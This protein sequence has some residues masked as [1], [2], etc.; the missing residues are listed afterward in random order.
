MLEDLS[1]LAV[2]FRLQSQGQRNLATLDHTIGPCPHV[3]CS[4]PPSPS[5]D[6]PLQ[7]SMVRSRCIDQYHMWPSTLSH[8]P[9]ALFE[10]P[11]NSIVDTLPLNMNFHWQMK[12]DVDHCPLCSGKHLAC[13]LFYNCPFATKISTLGVTAK[14]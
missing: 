5:L 1:F 11:L 4:V 13:T 7:G 14:F 12:F 3:V 8:L 10:W 2:S 9:D 6:P